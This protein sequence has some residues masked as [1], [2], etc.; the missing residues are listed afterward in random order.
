[1]TSLTNGL[2]TQAALPG[3]LHGVA[4]V[5]NH[6]GYGAVGLLIYLESLGAPLPGETV[7]IAAAVYAGTGQLNVVLLGVV[8]VMAAVLGDNSA[9]LIGR[10]GGARVVRRF[11][12][13]VLL[14]PERVA[15][16][17]DVFR[18]RGPVV[19]F[20]GRFIAL[21]RQL[22]G[23]LAGIAQLP[24]GVFALCDAL[25]CLAWVTFWTAVGY[26]A[27]NHLDAWRHHLTGPMGWLALAAA[28]A[29]AF[30][31]VLR[32]RRAHKPPA[33]RRRFLA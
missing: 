18:R 3:F 27:G 26:L 16:G 20:V 32:H 17:Q 30:V 15:R 25:G 9:Y 19:V 31:L 13:Y 14:T 6:Y 11:G 23:F 8:A 12:R 5:L 10:H 24:W 28:V 29:A 7:L 2:H 1:M 22:N 21:L 33:S 4:P